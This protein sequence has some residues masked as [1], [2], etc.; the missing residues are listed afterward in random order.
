MSKIALSLVTDLNGSKL[1]NFAIASFILSQS[2]PVDIH[3]YQDGYKRQPHERLAELATS[4]GFKI[5]THE[6]SSDQFNGYRSAKH[7]TKTQF[8]KFIA[9]KDLLGEYERVLYSDTDILFMRDLDLNS[10]DFGGCPL[11]ACFDVA[12]V[13]GIT[14]DQ[15]AANCERNGLSKDYF[16]SGL[17]FFNSRLIDEA[18]LHINYQRLLAEHQKACSYK[19]PCNTNDQC[20][21]NLLFSGRWKFLPIGWNVQSSMRF[22]KTWRQASVR[23]YTGPKKFLPLAAWRSDMIELKL[24][25]KIAAELGESIYNPTSPLGSIYMLNS[26]RWRGNISRI[27]KAVEVVNQ[28]LT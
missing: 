23:H 14:N 26:L 4:R 17:M 16:N 12:E 18:A 27:D 24:V 9:V 3:L 2:K 6:L 20:V 7:I 21:W 8:L 5:Q 11:A 10:V 25:R 19:T 22:T 1:A 15:F 13:S 28:R